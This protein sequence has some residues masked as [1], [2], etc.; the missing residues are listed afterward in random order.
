MPQPSGKT[1]LDRAVIYGTSEYGEG[2]QH[3]EKEHPI[4][5]AGRGGGRL[6]AGFHTREPG[7]KLCKAQLT[8]LR[9]L[10]LPF[11][12]FGYSGAQTSSTVDGM[13][14]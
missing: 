8:V 9:A 11:D 6:K 14:V 2:W 10:G 1:L 5:I 13:L 3:G 7:G 4:L 12:S